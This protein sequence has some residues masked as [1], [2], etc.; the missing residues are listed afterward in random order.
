MTLEAEYQRILKKHIEYKRKNNKLVLIAAV[1]P[2]LYLLTKW[3]VWMLAGI[4]YIIA[5]LLFSYQRNNV[6][7]RSY[8][9]IEQQ[10]IN[11]LTE[12][13]KKIGI[14]Q[15]T[16]RPAF[17]Y[18]VTAKKLEPVYLY[19]TENYLYMFGNIFIKNC[20]Y[21]VN[22][23]AF[24]CFELNRVVLEEGYK[25]LDKHSMLWKE[26]KEN[27]QELLR[28]E[29]LRLNNLMIIES[30]IYDDILCDMI[31]RKKKQPM[32]IQLELTNL[33]KE[34]LIQ[35]QLDDMTLVLEKDTAERI[36][37]YADSI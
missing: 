37:I 4:V 1:F 21:A 9:Q 23:Q 30:F 35:T 20:V 14:W 36:G 26:R 17:G 28:A 11:L 16:G 2:I 24:Y 8:E 25:T 6:L 3:D 31:N 18:C 12:R 22:D 32:N 27:H 19:E 13:L 33:K 7:C 10:Q 34:K 5:I 15:E 29:G